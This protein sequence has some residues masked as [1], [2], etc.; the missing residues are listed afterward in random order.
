MYKRSDL[1]SWM[2]KFKKFQARTKAAEEAI[3][4]I[5]EQ[6]CSGSAGNAADADANKKMKTKKIAPALA[7]CL[8]FLRGFYLTQ[9]MP[10]QTKR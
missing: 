1:R 10:P 4:T 3:N 8:D 6:C 2:S 9:R 7:A 5:T